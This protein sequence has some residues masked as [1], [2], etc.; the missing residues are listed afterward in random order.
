MAQ[1]FPTCSP[2]MLHN[3]K[4]FAVAL[5]NLAIGILLNVRHRGRFDYQRQE[6]HVRE[7]LNSSNRAIWP[8]RASFRTRQQGIDGIVSSLQNFQQGTGICLSGYSAI[9]DRIASGRSILRSIRRR[10][11][12]NRGEKGRNIPVRHA[13]SDH[14]DGLFDAGRG[15]VR[16]RF[17]TRRNRGRQDF[18]VQVQDRHRPI[19]RCRKLL[20]Q[21]MTPF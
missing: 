16:Q 10:R 7:P 17:W 11:L 1:R 4:G 9:L 15:C 2:Q 21:T 19:C 12:H 8:A 5:P 20:S 14:R 6:N 3:L 18:T 13:L